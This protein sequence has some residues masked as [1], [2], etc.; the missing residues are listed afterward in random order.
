MRTDPV[1]LKELQVDESIPGGVPFGKG[2][3]L[4]SQGI[5]PIAQG[6]VDA[7]NVNSGRCGDHFAQDGT[8]LDGEQLAMLIAILDGLGQVHVGRHDQRGPSRLTRAHRLTIGTGED[9]RIAPPAITGPLQGTALGARDGEGHRSLNEIVADTPSGPVGSF[10]S[11]GYN[12]YSG[13][14]LHAV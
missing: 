7:L 12:K 10:L 4:A 14:A 13:C 1:V 8:D 2:M 9:R 11:I 6:A 3:G 5:E